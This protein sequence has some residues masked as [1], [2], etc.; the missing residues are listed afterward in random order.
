MSVNLKSN[1]TDSS[2]H[3]EQTTDW[4]FVIMLMMGMLSCNPP[5]TARDG[6]IYIVALKTRKV[7]EFPEPSLRYRSKSVQSLRN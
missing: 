5:K 4:S 7:S 6:T 2:L 1:E 3:G